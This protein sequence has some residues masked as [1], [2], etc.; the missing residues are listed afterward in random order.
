MGTATKAPVVVAVAVAAAVVAAVIAARTAEVL[1]IIPA[2]RARRRTVVARDR[3]PT[4]RC[5]T[6]GVNRIRGAAVARRRPPAQ[7]HPLVRQRRDADGDYE[8]AAGPPTGSTTYPY[9]TTRGPRDYLARN[10]QS[11]GP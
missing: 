10:P 9:Y 3:P 5:R 6:I 1:R 8:F 11:I 7:G 4:A 2:I